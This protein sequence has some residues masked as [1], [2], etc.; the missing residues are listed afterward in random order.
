MKRLLTLLVDHPSSWAFANPVNAA[1]VTD[2]Y[3]VIK[4]PMGEWPSGGPR[5]DY[6]RGE[7]PLTL[8]AASAVH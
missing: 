3:D 1:E 5:S 6:S 2:Y 8:V 4:E 7:C